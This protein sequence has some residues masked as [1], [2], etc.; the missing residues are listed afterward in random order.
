MTKGYLPEF[1]HPDETL[2]HLNLICLMFIQTVLV[3][4]VLLQSQGKGKQ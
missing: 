4:F 1:V 3:S 2:L